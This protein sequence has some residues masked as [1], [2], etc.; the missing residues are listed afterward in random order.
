[1]RKKIAI[2][3]GVLAVGL[4]SCG[5]E[6]QGLDNLIPTVSADLGL[7]VVTP[8]APVVKQPEAEATPTAV[9]MP[10]LSA[11]FSTSTGEVFN[12]Y[13]GENETLVIGVQTEFTAGLDEYVQKFLELDGLAGSSFVKEKSVMYTGDVSGATNTDYTVVDTIKISNPE[14]PYDDFEV[15]LQRDSALFSGYNQVQV[16]LSSSE[17][18]LEKHQKIAN[19]LLTVVLGK[20]RADY[21]TSQ[22]F[23]EGDST[24]S[25]YSTQEDSLSD[26]MSA[27]YTKYVSDYSVSYTYELQ[28]ADIDLIRYGSYQMEY[29]TAQLPD[30]GLQSLFPGLTKLDYLSNDYMADYFGVENTKTSFVNVVERKDEF[31]TSYS[32]STATNADGHTVNLSVIKDGSDT[33]ISVSDSV[34]FNLGDS[35]AAQDAIDTMVHRIKHI[36]PDAQIEVRAGDDL[37][38]DG[39]SVS[40]DMYYTDVET[41]INLDGQ[42]CAAK[43]RFDLQPVISWEDDSG[44]VYYSLVVNK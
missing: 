25:G 26:T 36:Y 3:A 37:E 10:T 43:V 13:T 18:I 21:F 19:G 20:E 12:T 5:K 8:T 34:Y 14:M 30:V 35:T 33:S 32:L 1:M 44:Y 2:I 42:T 39:W 40:G 31:G 41:T 22:N 23:G 4:A 29:K 16:M 38:A 9:P 17:G 6:E 11:E 28:S 7:D 27:I 24:D 15:V